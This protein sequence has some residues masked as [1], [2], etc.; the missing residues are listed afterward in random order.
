MMMQITTGREAFKSGTS[1]FSVLVMPTPSLRLPAPQH[2]G[3]LAK[4]ANTSVPIRSTYYMRHPAASGSM[5]DMGAWH[6]VHYE[7]PEGMVLKLLGD[8]TVMASTYGQRGGGSVASRAALLIQTR[9]DAALRRISF[10][11][12]GDPMSTYNDVR[13]EGRFDLLSLKGALAAGMSIDLRRATEYTDTAALGRLFSMEVLD[14]EI[15]A[16]KVV[17]T[18]P[19][20]TDNGVVHIAS[21]SRRRAIDLD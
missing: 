3:L 12:V 21:S 11:M 16:Q 5:V 13:V 20:M 8:K 7:V 10:R 17:R 15:A 2:I 18:T 14:K 9:S 4:G 19:V 1:S 6:Q